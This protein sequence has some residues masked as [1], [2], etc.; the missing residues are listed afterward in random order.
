[1]LPRILIVVLFL[2][3]GAVR[4]G[5]AQGL[6][7]LRI[8]HYNLTNYG[9]NTS[10]CT[11]NNNGL[12]KKDSLLRIILKSY[13][14]DVFTV[15]ELGSQSIL[16]ARIK[17][18]VMDSLKLNGYDF[19]AGS[20]FAGSS[21]INAIY[22]NNEKLRFARKATVRA[23]VRDID[24]FTLYY[25]DPQLGL[26]TTD[27][28]WFNVAILHLKAGN[29]SA[30]IADRG[31]M[32]DSLMLRVA[33]NYRRTNLIVNGD[34]NVYRS[35]ETGFIRLTSPTVNPTVRL[36]DPINQLGNWSA[37]SNYRAIHTQSSAVTGGCFSGGGMDDRFDMILAN[38]WVMNDSAGCKVLPATYSAY[39]NNGSTYN[40]RI[41]SNSNTNTVVSRNVLDAL[42]GSS[43]HIP[44]VT[45]IAFKKATITS[46][47]KEVRTPEPV[48]YMQ[49]GR[50]F[51]SWQGAPDGQLM[52]T[53]YSLSGAKVYQGWA[54]GLSNEAL[55][56]GLYLLRLLH[57]NY[58]QRVLRVV[59][60]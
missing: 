40:D 25:K 59:S 41:N 19:S 4:W 50:L 47:A 3:L 39:G 17:A 22:F 6:D 36:F 42:A 15:N 8:M 35:S 30:D 1:M 24:I 53:V 5:R 46:V 29:T 37:N 26:S 60:Q 23:Q 13:R 38:S 57:P 52:S 27:T 33:R 18:R 32:A 45:S 51:A 14:P 10:F 12:N 7:T 54:D 20:N 55:P 16:S 31:R 28:V 2:T 44:V 9:N 58:G 21:I 56:Q 34:Y 43:D 11:T 48:V 49:N